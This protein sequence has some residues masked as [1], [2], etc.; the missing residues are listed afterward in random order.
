MQPKLSSVKTCSPSATT[1]MVVPASGN[2]VAGFVTVPTVWPSR[3][4]RKS[5]GCRNQ[6]L[7]LP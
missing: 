7:M 2:A 1:E 3:Y 4:C 6:S 5:T